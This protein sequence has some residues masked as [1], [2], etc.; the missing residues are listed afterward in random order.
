MTCVVRR[1]LAAA[2]SAAVVTLLVTIG[3]P[4][5]AQE[6]GAAKS[7]GTKGKQ[8]AKVSSPSTE[9][10]GKTKAT[11]KVAPPDP[12]HRVPPGYAR[13]GLTDQQKDRIY[14][15]QAD[16]YPKVQGLQK[17]LDG[18][19]AE[20]DAK[21]EAVLTREQ[22]SMLAQEE[23]QKKAASAARKAAGKTAAKQKSSN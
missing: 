20:R 12:T 17:Q 16:Y 21:F 2:A 7:Q 8:A 6:G 14:K 1:S 3:N 5:S 11:G 10:S 15:I 18:L 4:L 9:S 22:K 13:L 23:Q 19:R